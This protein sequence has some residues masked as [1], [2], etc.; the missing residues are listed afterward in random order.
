MR[1]N[2]PSLKG[3][4]IEIVDNFQGEE[5]KIILL[6]LVRSNPH[7]IGFLSKMNRIC[8]ALT[9]AREGF[10]L[11]G[12]MTTL[13]GNSLVWKGIYDTLQSSKVIG[14][15]HFYCIHLFYLYKSLCY[16]KIFFSG[17]ELPLK[18]STHGTITEVQTTDDFSPL[19]FGGCTLMCGVKLE[20]GHVC[21]LQCHGTD[22]CH[23]GTYSCRKPCERYDSLYNTV[24]P[25]HI[26]GH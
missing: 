9:R 11:I 19:V 18:C 8:V 13:K 12:N 24:F 6:S 15:N 17:N 4:S 26:A 21:E 10:Y 1:S 23:L 7:S 2:Y 5:N 16:D 22:E 14:N 20:C 3:V 25:I